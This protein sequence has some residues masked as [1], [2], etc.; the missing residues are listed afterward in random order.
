MAS[1][2]NTSSIK[3]TTKAVFHVRN[4]KTRGLI[5][6][7]IKV[8]GSDDIHFFRYHHQPIHHHVEQVRNKILSTKIIR[9]AEVEIDIKEFFKRIHFFLFRSEIFFC[10]FIRLRYSIRD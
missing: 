9:E 6:E 2:E 4:H 7:S 1:N 3:T 10:L 8:L 5:I